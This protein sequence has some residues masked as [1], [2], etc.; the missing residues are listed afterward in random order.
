VTRKRRGRNRNEC[1]AD[2]MLCA[3]TLRGTVGTA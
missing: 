3:H 2:G 1:H